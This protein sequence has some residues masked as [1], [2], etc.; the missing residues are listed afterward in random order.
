MDGGEFM[1]GINVT[2]DSARICR[3]WQFYS[4]RQRENQK[5]FGEN[6]ENQAA[7]A[8]GDVLHAGAQ[9]VVKYVKMC[10]CRPPPFMHNAYR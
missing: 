10:L 5:F 7:L 1:Y 9:L 2:A 8:R 4:A 6:G 3:E